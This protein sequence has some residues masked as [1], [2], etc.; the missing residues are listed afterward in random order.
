MLDRI[1]AIIDE[2]K[3]RFTFDRCGIGFGG[4]VDFQS[5]RVVLSTHVAGWE[6]FRSAASHLTRLARRPAR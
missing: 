5:Q 3:H 4:P 6:R 2:W 1:A